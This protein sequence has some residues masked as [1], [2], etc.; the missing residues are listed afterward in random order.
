MANE[1][2]RPTANG[3]LTEL[4]GVGLENWEAVNDVKPDGYGTFIRSTS[5]NLQRD[6]YL[7]QNHQ[8]S[9]TILRVD[10]YFRTTHHGEALI[11]PNLNIYNG[12]LINPNPGYWTTSVQFWLINPETQQPWTWQD[13]D[14]LQFGVAMCSHSAGG[15]GGGYDPSNCTQVFMLVRTEGLPKSYGYIIT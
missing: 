8:Q 3:D 15:K 14:N 1:I 4:E 6:L 9:G 7:H 2:F 13:I 5:I 11:K 12:P 10:I